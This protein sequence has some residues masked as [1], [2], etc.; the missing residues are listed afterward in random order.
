MKLET[1]HNYP[2]TILAYGSGTPECL[3]IVCCHAVMSCTLCLG[4]YITKVSH[5]TNILE[6]KIKPTSFI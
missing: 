2:L 6:H 4:S 5:A 3:V 1:M